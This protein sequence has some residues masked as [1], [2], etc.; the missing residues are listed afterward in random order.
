M[1]I[2]SSGSQLFLMEFIFVVLFLSLSA[3]ICMNAFAK[4]DGV[5]SKAY[6]TEEAMIMAQGLADSLY[7]AGKYGMN[8]EIAEDQ[9]KDLERDGFLK[10]GYS[11]KV[12][13]G[14]H[15]ESEVYKDHIWKA[16]VRVYD[17][18][19]QQLCQLPVSR[20]VAGEVEHG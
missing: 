9:V 16:W 6:A 10:E 18:H 4:A 11:F 1:K 20:Y 17:S 2:R 15:Q 14:Q 8:R 13:V 5:S 7:E 12:E 19:D 3:A